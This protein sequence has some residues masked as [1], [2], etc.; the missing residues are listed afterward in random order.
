MYAFKIRAPIFSRGQLGFRGKCGKFHTLLAKGVGL[1]SCGTLLGFRRSVILVHGLGAV[2]L[3]VLVLALASFAARAVLPGPLILPPVILQIIDPLAVAIGMGGFARVGSDGLHAYPCI[4][5]LGARDPAAVTSSA[6]AAASFHVRGLFR[7]LDRVGTSWLPCRILR[8][9]WSSGVLPLIAV[10]DAVITVFLPLRGQVSLAQQPPTRNPPMKACIAVR[11]STFSHSF[12]VA[13][14]R[15]QPAKDGV[16]LEVA[17]PNTSWTNKHHGGHHRVILSGNEI[18]GLCLRLHLRSRWWWE[19]C[20]GARKM[21]FRLLIGVAPAAGSGFGGSFWWW[22]PPSFRLLRAQVAAYVAMLI[23]LRPMGPGF[24]Q[25]C[26]VEGVAEDAKLGVVA[27]E[28]GFIRELKEA[29]WVANP[30]MVPKKDTTALRMYIDYTDLNKHFPKDHIP[31]P[32]IDQ[33]VDSTAGCDRLSFLDAYSG[34]NQIKLKK[35]DQS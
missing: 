5:S 15:V 31:L 11:L 21:F 6:L 27:M 8:P 4:L 14:H 33:I 19:I 1:V 30:V 13:N 7:L 25:D 29:E 26:D 3:F 35:E 23:P 22:S 34:Y 28:H 12:L 24:R 10:A 16:L 32:H 18:S 2:L 20:E 9:S 17:E